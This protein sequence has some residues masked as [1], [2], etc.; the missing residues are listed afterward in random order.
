MKVNCYQILDGPQMISCEYDVAIDLIKQKNARI[1]IDMQGAQ[2]NEFEEKLDDLD[3]RGLIRRFCLESRDHP[4]FYPLK[5]LS[6][7]VLPVHTEAK[8]FS[9]MEYLS[10]LYGHNLLLSFQKKEM[11]HF[12]KDFS[13]EEYVSLLPD[14]HVAGIISSFALGLSLVSLR[15]A[16]FLNDGILALEEKMDKAPNTVEIEEISDKRMEMLSM[17]SVVHGQLPIF[18]A[19]MSSDSASINLVHSKDYLLWASANLK[20]ADRTLEWLERRIDVMRSFFDAKAQEK[21]N[22][23]LARLTVLSTIFMPITFLA[24]VWGMNFEYMP[25]LSFRYGYVMALGIM[26]VI[27]GAM[28][29]YFRKKGWFE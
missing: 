23:R 15:K 14:S 28:Y 26:F 13:L 4:G 22:R 12:Q 24:G 6:L 19:L 21:T 18:L 11:T 3:I 10:F 17:E 2:L 27:A 1:W 20:S 9:G 29:F 16:A 5:P 25:G 8:N 7:L